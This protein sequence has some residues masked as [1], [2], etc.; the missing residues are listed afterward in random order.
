MLYLKL[1]VLKTYKNVL[2][3]I[4]QYDYFMVD[5]VIIDF[6]PE[7]AEILESKVVYSI[8][9]PENH[10]DLVGFE[11]ATNFFLGHKIT[12][13]DQLIAIGGGSLSD[14]AGFVAASLLRGIEWAV[15]PTTLLSMI[16]A[17]IGGKVGINTDH[18]KNLLGSFHSPVFNVT[19]LEFLKTLPK[20]DYQSGLGEMLKYIFLD[21]EIHNKFIQTKSFETIIEDCALYKQ[22]IV[23]EDLYE[24]GK[25]K[26]LNL[27]HTFG[28]GIEFM[29]DLPH[30][31][32][33]YFGL[34]M[35]IKFLCPHMIE[36]LEKVQSLFKLEIEKMSKVDI[37][38]LFHFMSFDK[39]RNED[40]SIDFILL[41][42]IGKPA[43]KKFKLDE[44]RK[45]VEDNEF[46][47]DYFQT[48]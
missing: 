13:K 1:M 16:D 42:D 17:S 33:V 22:N 46:Y 40:Q 48:N 23:D 35:M 19:T 25:R 29:T 41:D 38:I 27:G 36:K 31:I 45:K 32:C 24:G 26:I 20:A 37:D 15:I 14:L 43:I 28:H 12:R 44:L 8:H 10:K 5:Q 39:K 6:Y 11:R 3:V 7:I 34:E 4:E 47:G 21:S 18:G 9:E 30:G 2:Q